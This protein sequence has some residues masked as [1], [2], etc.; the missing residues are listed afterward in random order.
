MTYSYEQVLTYEVARD[1]LN[2][3]IADCSAAL[4]DEKAKDKPST[5]RLTKLRD[6]QTELVVERR[7]MVMTDDQAMK[8]ILTKY[9]REFA[10]AAA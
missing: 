8:K 1:L 6:M 4:A 9:R 2:T 3:Y 10:H 5:K 7:K